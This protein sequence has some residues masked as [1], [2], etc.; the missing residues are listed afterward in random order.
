MRTL[1]ATTWFNRIALLVLS[2]GV[3]YLF[4]QGQTTAAA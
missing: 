1:T 4:V 3:A 2:A